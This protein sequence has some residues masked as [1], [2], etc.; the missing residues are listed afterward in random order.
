MLHM[1]DLFAFAAAVTSVK[2]ITMVVVTVSL[3]LVLTGIGRLSPTLSLGSAS[4]L[5]VLSLAA[6]FTC[7]PLRQRVFQQGVWPLTPF[8]SRDPAKPEIF[9]SERAYPLWTGA[10]HGI[11]KNFEGQPVE[12]AWV[13][14]ERH[15]VPC[16]CQAP[17]TQTDAAGR[18]AL[19]ALAFGDYLVSASRKAEV[20]TARPFQ[21]IALTPASRVKSLEFRLTE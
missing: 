7:G 1:R 20:A 4:A 8:L 18:F 14:A 21:S 16:S 6:W 17:M 5:L 15:D 19:H 11:V 3:L 13:T 2:G 12:G 9:W 10:I